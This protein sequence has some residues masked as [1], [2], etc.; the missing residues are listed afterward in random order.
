MIVFTEHSLLKL[1]QRNI[2]K[3]L[4]TKVLKNPDHISKSH[5]NRKVCYKKIGQL[6]LKVIYK[7][8]VE[9]I[10]VITQYFIKKIE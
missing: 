10:I 6:Y 8:E 1:K 9:D 2:L 3:S 4:V 5:S 7:E